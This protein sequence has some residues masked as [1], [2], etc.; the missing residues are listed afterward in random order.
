MRKKLE[1]TEIW[2][3]RRVLNIKKSQKSLIIPISIIQRQIKFI[4]EKSK[5]KKGL[6]Q[7]STSG[8]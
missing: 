1:V 6:E 8:K 2:L 5:E 4:G 7:L 3:I